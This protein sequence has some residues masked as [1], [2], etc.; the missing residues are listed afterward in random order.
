[1]KNICIKWFSF[2]LKRI[3]FIPPLI[4]QTVILL[5]ALMLFNSC[6]SDSK[7][8]KY[9]KVLDSNG[10]TLVFFNNIDAGIMEWGAAEKSN[11]TVPSEN[12]SEWS[13]PTIDELELLYKSEKI[14]IAYKCWSSDVTSKYVR[15]S[16][17]S[18]GIYFYAKYLDF[19]SGKWGSELYSQQFDYNPTTSVGNAKHYT[20]YVHKVKRGNS[21]SINISQDT[22]IADSLPS[23]DER[24]KHNN[25]I[26]A[27]ND[28]VNKYLIKK[29]G[30]YVDLNEVKMPSNTI[31]YSFY[32]SDSHA[33]E[34]IIILN[35]KK[36]WEHWEPSGTWKYKD[37]DEQ[38][39]K[40]K[41]RDTL[42]GIV[43]QFDYQFYNF[44]RKYYKLLKEDKDYYYISIK[45]YEGL[46]IKDK[47][48]YSDEGIQDQSW[49]NTKSNEEEGF[50]LFSNDE[51]KSKVGLLDKIGVKEDCFLL[52]K[53]NGPTRI[54]QFRR[55][56]NTEGFTEDINILDTVFRYQ[57]A[58]KILQ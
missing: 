43:G 10:D 38:L 57:F 53:R 3:K 2:F 19:N 50:Q 17:I 13:L 54:I 27:H 49:E 41:N 24:L 36:E 20:I 32:T 30:V 25:D 34:Y 35:N 23:L 55:T 22:I 12:Y 46:V 45:V 51:E 37:F 42:F 5:N 48:D 9:I 33:P 1:M 11:I 6:G 28:Q 58:K 29:Y 39:K 18:A 21:A 47:V 52:P 7:F 56:Q 14:K 26:N 8:E 16:P 15:V 4:A 40:L 31:A 44:D